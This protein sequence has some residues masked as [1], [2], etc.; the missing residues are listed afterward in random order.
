MPTG[1]PNRRG[2]APGVAQTIYVKIGVRIFFRRS[3][4]FSKRQGPRRA[5]ERFRAVRQKPTGV[6]KQPL[7][8]MTRIRRD[9]GGGRTENANTYDTNNI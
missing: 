9:M 1:F 7:P 5:N 6:R 2:F 4:R 8:I 3:R